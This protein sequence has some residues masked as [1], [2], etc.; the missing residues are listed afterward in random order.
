[1]LARDFDE[2]ERAGQLAMALARSVGADDVLAEA[3]VQSGV[4]LAMNGSPDGLE[5]IREG[6]DLADRT[7]N[8]YIVALGYSQI[9]SGYGE[10][11]DYAVAVPALRQGI[12]FAEARQ[13]GSAYYMRAWLAR[14]ELEL[15]DWDAAG[16]AAVDLV[17]NPRCVGISRF[18]ALVTLAWVR[19]RRGDP[20]VRPLLDEALEMARAMTHLQRLWPVAACRA[21]QAWLEGELEREVALIDEAAALAAEL[22]YP[23][24]I[25]E[26]AHWRSIADGEPR[27][28]VE[29]AR[30]PFG[31][32]AAGRPDLAA[33]RWSERGCPY[34]AAVARY[35]SGTPADLRAAY[36]AFDALGAAPMRAR[37]ATALREAGLRVPRGPLAATRDNPGALTDRELEVV[38]LLAGGRTNR[39]IAEALVISV[40]TA[41]HHVSSVLAKLGVRSRSEAAVAAVKMGITVHNV[42]DTL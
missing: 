11:R 36:E 30:T 22:A 5:R 31:L 16:S 17:R 27:C 18:V 12:A 38:A 4:A 24:A 28:S 23:P 39:E 33:Q 42:S 29:S 15:G 41:E 34:E 37:T 14:C 26:L 1:M 13:F 21:E 2:A 8:D 10:L 32:S 25:E 40:K 9:G 20:E 19:G 7:G 35:L 6:I 3:C